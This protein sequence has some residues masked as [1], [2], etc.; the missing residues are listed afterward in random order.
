M[1]WIS[2]TRE[3]VAAIMPMRENSI[4]F[5]VKLSHGEQDFK[6]MPSI[7][8][9]HSEK[10]ASQKSWHEANSWCKGLHLPIFHSK[11]DEA[12]FLLA[13]KEHYLQRAPRFVYRL[14]IGM[15]YTK[16]EMVN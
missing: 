16:Y 14:F 3:T 11:Q 6:I 8:Q 4:S 12:T 5:R 13:Y 10:R 7:L 15:K 1:A 9:Y 2:D